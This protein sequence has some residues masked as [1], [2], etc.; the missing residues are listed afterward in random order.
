MMDVFGIFCYFKIQQS[1]NQQILYN[2]VVAVLIT[3]IIIKK[4][5]NKIWDVTRYAIN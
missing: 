2:S 4:L 1:P 3:F 5:Y